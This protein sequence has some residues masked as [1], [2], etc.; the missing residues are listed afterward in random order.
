M[1]TDHE[2]DQM[3]IQILFQPKIPWVDWSID[4]ESMFSNWQLLSNKKDR[5]RIVLHKRLQDG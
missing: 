3:K 1:I 4:I 5:Y 2:R